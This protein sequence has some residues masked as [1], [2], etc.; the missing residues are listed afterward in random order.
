[1]NYFEF[2]EPMAPLGL[3]C[4][5]EYASFALLIHLGPCEK[6][7]IHEYTNVALSR[8][9]QLTLSTHLLPIDHQEK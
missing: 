5:R 4:A 9:K 6:L 7:L 2:L 8:L 3:P 1:M